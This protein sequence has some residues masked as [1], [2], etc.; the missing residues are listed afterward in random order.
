MA[1][2][3]VEQRIETGIPNLEVV[4]L[5]ASDEETYQS[6]K[7]RVIEGALLCVNHDTDTSVNVE[8]DDSSVINGTQD[9][10]IIN[11]Q[12]I[13]SKTVSLLLIGRQ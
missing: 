4:R 2:A 11:P 9:G 1:A 13:S 8:D 6:K 10:V 5:E 7:L 3:D 12:G